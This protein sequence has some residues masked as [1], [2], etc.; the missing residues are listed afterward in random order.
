[1]ASKTEAQLKFDL[2]RQ[3]RLKSRVHERLK[4]THKE[5]IDKYN[6]S[7]SKLSDHYDIP[8]VGPG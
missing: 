4:H 7:L 1:M 8:R 6:E 3:K 2:I 5:R